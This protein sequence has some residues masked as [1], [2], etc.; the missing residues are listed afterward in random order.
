[1]I[2][3]F[4]ISS[5]LL[6]LLISVLLSTLSNLY[7]GRKLNTFFNIALS[8]ITIPT[9]HTKSLLDE[10]K[11]LLLD[12]PHLS[13]ENLELKK[14]NAVLLSENQ[15][16]KN[17][18]TDQ[19]TL[20]NSSKIFTSTIPIRVV[21]VGNSI[22]ATTSF[23]TNSI[24]KGQPVISGAILLGF[25]DRVSNSI[26]HITPLD[27]DNLPRFPI[28]TVM[29]QSGIYLFENRS[30]QI[31]DLPSENPINLND[32]ILT[33]PTELIPANLVLGRTT[34]IISTPQSPL[35]RAEISLDSKL[36]TKTPDPVIIT[37]P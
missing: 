7:I 10:T 24:K 5:L 6:P 16:L 27:S 17:A 33:L 11:D 22:T 2:N 35:Q 34:K 4:R 8:P 28:K 15:N 30:S 19:E 31:A 26:I 14:I 12:L 21:S 36:T 1:M 18:I 37:K 32:S 23:D 29:G 3:N 9:S 25:V 20:K 13:R